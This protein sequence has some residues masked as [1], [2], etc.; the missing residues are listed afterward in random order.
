MGTTMMVSTHQKKNSKESKASIHA[1]L[2]LV[3]KSGKS[4][5]GRNSTIKSLHLGNSK[6]V[7]ISNN[8]PSVWTSELEYYAMLSKTG[9]YH[10]AGNNVEL[11]TNCG[12]FFRICSMSITNSGDS[13]IVKNKKNLT[14][15]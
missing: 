3:L 6:L 2:Q 15:I 14:Y 13:D 12:K 10:F 9:I 7:I 1:K 8:C 11:G 5:F 4:T